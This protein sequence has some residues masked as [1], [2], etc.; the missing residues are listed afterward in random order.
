MTATFMASVVSGSMVCAIMTPFDVVCT[1]LYNQGIDHSTK[2]GQSLGEWH[3][4]AIGYK[5][6]LSEINALSTPAPS[7][8][9][10]RGVP[11]HPNVRAEEHDR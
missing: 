10:S 1:R 3:C 9:S 5:D 4:R 2:K 11:S 6:N 8:V 7:P